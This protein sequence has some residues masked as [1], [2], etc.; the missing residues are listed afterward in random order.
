MNRI[1]QQFH[2]KP[3]YIG[4][5]TGGDGGVDYCVDCSLALVEGGV[6]I[7][8]LGMPF[9]DPVADGPVIQQA[10]QRALQRGTTPETVLEISRRVRQEADVPIILFTYYNPLLQK[11]PDFLKKARSVGVDAVLVVDLPPPNPDHDSRYFFNALEAA[12]LDPIFVTAPSTDQK[13]LDQIKDISKG[14]IYY[15]CQK[16]TTGVRSHLPEDFPQ[17]ISKIRAGTNLPIAAG[18]GIASRE[19]AQ[20][21]L[22]YADGFVV[23]SAFVKQM[24]DGADPAKLCAL[25]RAIDPR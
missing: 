4:F 15:A 16:G 9:S 23:G 24:A 21:A 2:K 18:F 1:E 12:H 6:D 10:S 7:L 8:E 5:L 11:G 3:A 14:F 25:A 20:E 22:Q 13:R 17:Q 19:T